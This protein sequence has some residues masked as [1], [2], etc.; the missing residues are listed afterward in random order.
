MILRFFLPSFRSALA[1]FS[2]GPLIISLLC[3]IPLLRF[4]CFSCA[5]LHEFAT[6]PRTMFLETPTIGSGPI[7]GVLLPCL[8][9]RSALDID[10]F[11]THCKI[12]N[13][14]KLDFQNNSIFLFVNINS[15][16]SVNTD[17]IR[18][19]FKKYLFIEKKCTYISALMKK[20][21]IIHT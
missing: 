16:S 12:K 21:T 4:Q 10:Y 9:S 13:K 15:V 14:C 19:N 3:F 17:Y 6:A 5:F 20:K 2:C 7:G 11:I 8:A 18:F 1:R